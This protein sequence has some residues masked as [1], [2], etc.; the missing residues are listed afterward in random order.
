MTAYRGN[1][2][3]VPIILNLGTIYMAVSGQLHAPATLPPETNS[4]D[5][6]SNGSWRGSSTSAKKKLLLLQGIKTED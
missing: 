4:P 1:R 3:I 5:T 6:H 2:V